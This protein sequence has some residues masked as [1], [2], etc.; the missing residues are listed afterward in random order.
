MHRLPVDSFS[1]AIL[2]SAW[3]PPLRA[4]GRTCEVDMIPR[5]PAQIDASAPCPNGYSGVLYNDVGKLRRHVASPLGDM[6]RHLARDRAVD[7]RNP[8]V[9]V[10]HDGGLARV[11]LLADADVERQA[12]QHVDAVFLAHPLA[13][14][15]SEDML[16]VAA[17]RADM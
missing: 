13:A 11:G 1:H 6:D 17:V 2:L 8:S 3:R 9:R 10:R 7:L 12:A 4:P 15:C 16:F 5:D 14:A